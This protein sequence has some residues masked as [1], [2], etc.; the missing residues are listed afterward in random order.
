MSDVLLPA[1]SSAQERALEGATALIERVPVRVREVW[2]PDTCPP[3]VL[4][5]LAWAFSVDDWSPLWDEQQ[6]RQVIKNSIIVHRYKGTIGAVREAIA[7]LGANSQ[8]VEWFQNDP[9]GTPYTFSLRVDVDQVGASQEFFDALLDVV[10]STKNLRSHLDQSKLYVTSLA[11]PKVAVCAGVGHEVTVTTYN[12]PTL[13]LNE[14][15]IC[16]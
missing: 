1:N 9:E 16:F 4:P 2:N 11:G 14:N 3:E 7:A 15:I 13:V 5:W 10:M 8:V 6:K 12:I